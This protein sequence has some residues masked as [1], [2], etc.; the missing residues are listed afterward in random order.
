MNARCESTPRRLQIVHLGFEDPAMSGAGGGAVRTHAINRRIAVDHDITVLVQRFPGCV[1]RFE[2]G[3]RYLHVGTGAGRNRLSRLVGYVSGSISA[4]RRL[5][6]DLVVED[7]FAPISTM[8]APIWTGRPTIGVVQWLNARDKAR[9]YRLP[10]QFIERFG[11]RRH[12]R[13]I[14][15]SGGVAE[16]LRA[17]NSALT[18]DVIGN[19]VQPEAFQTRQ[20]LGN[21]VVFVGRLEIAQKGLDLLLHAWAQASQAVQGQLVIAGQGPDGQR[22]RALA[23]SLGI[24]DRVRFVGWVS[25]AAKFDLLASA[26]LVAVPSRFETFGL[27]ALE[28]LA[29]GTPVV[30][31]DIDCLRE[32]VP[33]GCGKRVTAFD[34]SAYATTLADSYHD[35]DWIRDAAPQAREFATGYDWDVLAAQ[36]QSVYVAAAGSTCGS[37]GQIS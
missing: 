11:V 30:A 7:F 9:Q 15:V 37:G 35:L 2:D 4:L 3:V 16:R 8:A 12:H 19:G 25:G 22:L 17:M 10:F 6:A 28:A 24:A 27:V 34:V 23:G 14:A 29:T 36:Q 5:P 1:D 31:F 13:L 20:H 21:D 26:R 33:V 18:V 32:V